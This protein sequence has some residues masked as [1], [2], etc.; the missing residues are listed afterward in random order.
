MFRFITFGIVMNK[1]NHARAPGKTGFSVALPDSLIWQI[2]EIAA[3]EHRSRNGQIEHFLT[4]AVARWKR[5]QPQTE[6]H[7]AETP[8]ATYAARTRDP[9][10][11]VLRERAGEKAR[12]ATGPTPPPPAPASDAH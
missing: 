5:E 3:A 9:A 8:Q 12:P 6:A 11:E 10:S 2:E 4:D 1:K 7:V